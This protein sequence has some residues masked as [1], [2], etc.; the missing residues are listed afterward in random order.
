MNSGETPGDDGLYS[1]ETGG[2]GGMLA[3]AALAVI[4]VTDDNNPRDR[5]LF[6]VF[7]GLQRP[8]GDIAFL[9]QDFHP[10]RFRFFTGRASTA[11]SSIL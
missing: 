7:Q 6:P 4:F 10:D 2:H 9:A 11:A 8:G 1:Q 3:G 5:G